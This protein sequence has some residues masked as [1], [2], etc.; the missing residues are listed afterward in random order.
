MQLAVLVSGSG[1]ILESLYE[2]GISIDLVVSDRKCRALEV[3]RSLEIE[4]SLVERTDFTDSFDRERYTEEL[5]DL[6]SSRDIGLVA[7]AGFGTILGEGIHAR[8]QRRIIN[9]HPS[10]LPAFPGWHAV[11]EALSYGVKLSGCTV[12]LA[13]LEVD[14]GPILAQQAV[15]VLP[16][17]SEGSLHERIKRVER[18]LYPKVIESYLKFLQGRNTA[19]LTTEELAHFQMEI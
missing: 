12:H 15:P 3:A 18:V 1:T 14:C 11:R 17:D 7:M 2:A 16:S 5:T 8:F 19:F 13:E 10:L 4:T 6:L 9:T